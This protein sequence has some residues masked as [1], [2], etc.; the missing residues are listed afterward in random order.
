VIEPATASGWGLAIL[1][2]LRE[3][4]ETIKAWSGRYPTVSIVPQDEFYNE[5]TLR[6]PDASRLTLDCL[7]TNGSEAHALMIALVECHVR[8]V[9]TVKGSSSTTKLIPPM[10][11]LK[12]RFVF[13]FSRHLTNPRGCKIILCDQFG[14]KHSKW[15][16]LKY[17]GPLFGVLP[18]KA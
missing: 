1:K 4:P 2:W 12:V 15:V 7:V 11:S 5:D 14:Q 9:G 8:G 17:R 13:E 18:P 6:H 16:T 10:Q 3:L